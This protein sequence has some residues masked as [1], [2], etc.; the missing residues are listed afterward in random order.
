MNDFTI[1]T[2]GPVPGSPAHT[3]PE[4]QFRA[5][6]GGY[7]QA[8]EK[9]SDLLEKMEG[10]GNAICKNKSLTFLYTASNGTR[11][12]RTVRPTLLYYGVSKRVEEPQWLFKGIE[13][14]SGKTKIYQVDNIGE[15]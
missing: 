9:A 7:I 3:F 5:V 6:N 4:H 12:F 15:L 2:I 8:A 11:S 13:E 10:I 1:V 14:A